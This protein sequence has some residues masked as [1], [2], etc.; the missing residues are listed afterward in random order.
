[1]IFSLTVAIL[2]CLGMVVAILRFPHIKL[3][4][5]SID[6]YWVV[7]LVGALVLLFSGRVNVSLLAK[8]LTESSPVNPIKILLLFLSMTLLS[9]FLDEVGFFRYLA[10]RTLVLAKHSQTKL[11]VLLY[12]VV[13]AVSPLQPQNA[14]LA[15]FSIPAGTS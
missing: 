15:I 3:G 2:V 7:S 8:R 10:S 6:S 1:M 4:K 9:V 11:F 13:I 5:L 14:S 12:I